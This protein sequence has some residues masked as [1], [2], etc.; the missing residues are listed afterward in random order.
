MK[1]RLSLSLSFTWWGIEIC[2]TLGPFTKPT[3][4]SSTEQRQW[5]KYNY[6]CSRNNEHRKKR[7]QNFFCQEL[8][9]RVQISLLFVQTRRGKFDLDV[10]K[11]PLCIPPFLFPK[12]LASK[13]TPPKWT[14]Q[15]E[16]DFAASGF[17]LPKLNLWHK[18]LLTNSPRLI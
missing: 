12:G 9:A 3:R 2:W 15:V 6:L 7:T 16:W 11:A 10:R 17:D 4:H 14:R 1:D 8:F 5:E 18:L 13:F